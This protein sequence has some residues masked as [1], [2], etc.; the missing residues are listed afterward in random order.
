MDSPGGGEGEFLDEVAAEAQKLGWEVR[1]G[2][3]VAGVGVDLLL[4]RGKSAI[5][6]L[7][8]QH[9]AG[10]PA[11]PFAEL[12]TL[13]RAGV[14]GLWLTRHEWTHARESFVALLETFGQTTP[15]P[16]KAESPAG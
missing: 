4:L 2:L 3:R 5:A 13:Q 15:T 11:H 12:E 1:R 7:P 10:G 9:A 6:L 16:E 8:G 14:V